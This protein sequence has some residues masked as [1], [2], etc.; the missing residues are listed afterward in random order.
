[1]YLWEDRECD[2]A[3]KNADE[4]VKCCIDS[5][6][7][8]YKT[9]L[10]DDH[11]GMSMSFTKTILNRLIDRKCLTPITEDDFTLTDNQIYVSDDYLRENNLKYEI[12]CPRY[13]ALFKSEDLEGNISYTDVNRVCCFDINDVYFPFYSSRATKFVD[14][15]FPIELPYM[16]EDKSYKLY[17]EEFL[18]NK[19]LEDFDTVAYCYVIT[20]D[21]Q[22]IEINRYFKKVVIKEYI[23]E[24]VEIDKQEYEYRKGFKIK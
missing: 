8:A 22:K 5:V 21:K 4:Y 23:T 24:W 11:S 3:K 12:Q 20:P 19:A 14:E 7:R 10:Q 18:I 15:M 2:L 9:L 1:M 13:T 17:I 16:P 6:L